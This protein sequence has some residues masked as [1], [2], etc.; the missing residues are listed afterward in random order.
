MFVENMVCSG[1]FCGKVV[2]DT[3]E[4]AAFTHFYHLKT[5]KTMMSNK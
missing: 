3:F 2:S 5:P 4:R 1:D